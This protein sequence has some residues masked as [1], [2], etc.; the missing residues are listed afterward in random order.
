MKRII[1]YFTA[2]KS[3]QKHDSPLVITDKPPTHNATIYS[4][5]A[6]GP[7]SNNL[8][9]T[10]KNLPRDHHH[11]PP[12]PRQNV[13]DEKKVLVKQLHNP[14]LV[15][16][17]TI[18]KPTNKKYFTKSLVDKKTYIKEIVEECGNLRGQVWVGKYLLKD[19]AGRSTFKYPPLNKL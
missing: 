1:Y 10:R 9:V 6:L 11:R 14:P 15:V 4:L 5:N 7:N 17:K 2:L 16:Q 18:Q 13:A 12:P 19:T 3:H 8:L